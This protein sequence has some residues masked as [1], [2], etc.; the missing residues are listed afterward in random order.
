VSAT[1]TLFSRR[2][3]TLVACAA[4]LASCDSVRSRSV[5]PDP[6]A[7]ATEEPFPAAAVRLHPLTRWV[8]DDDRHAVLEARFELFDRYGVSTR[9]LGR[10]LFVLIDA[11][12]EETRWDID[13]ANPEPNART[14]YD[15]VTRLYAVPLAL[16]S[17]PA[18]GPAELSVTYLTLDGRRISSRMAVE[19]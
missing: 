15:A 2:R 12:G 9:S 1:R 8:D 19:R 3:I 10:A 5:L 4:F 17:P 6:P 18:D 13:L 11:S 16:R 7:A 14:Y